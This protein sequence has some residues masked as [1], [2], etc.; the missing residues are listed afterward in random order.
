[1]AAQ[2]LLIQSASPNQLSQFLALKKKEAIFPVTSQ[3]AEA[4]LCGSP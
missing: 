1:M 2:H 4:N 3:A